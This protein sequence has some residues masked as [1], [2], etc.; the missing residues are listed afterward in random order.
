MIYKISKSYG[1]E[2]L[3]WKEGDK[4]KKLDVEDLFRV[5]R[6]LV[7]RLIKYVKDCIANS[8]QGIKLQDNPNMDSDMRMI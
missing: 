8:H 2:T 5:T 3:S 6:F 4:D 7:D 1:Q